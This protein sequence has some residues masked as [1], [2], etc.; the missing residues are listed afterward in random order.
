[1]KGKGVH[2]GQQCYF[3][4]KGHFVGLITACMEGKLVLI[5]ITKMYREGEFQNW[6]WDRHFLKVTQ[7]LQFNE[8]WTVAGLATKISLED[9]ICAFLKTIPEDCKN[10]NI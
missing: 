3:T 2:S 5:V 10:G 1:M 9:Q 4:C 6:N 7:Q 8:A